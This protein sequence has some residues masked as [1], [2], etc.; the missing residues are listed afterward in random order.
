MIF[1]ICF[2]LGSWW[3]TII[4]IYNLISTGNLNADKYSW[5]TPISNEDTGREADAWF[6]LIFDQELNLISSMN[7]ILPNLTSMSAA[8]ELVTV[9]G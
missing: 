7:I 3:D 9:T 5:L 6:P 1:L 4:N 2:A 8:K